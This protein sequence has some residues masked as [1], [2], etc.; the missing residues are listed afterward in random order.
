MDLNNLAP[1]FL[2]FHMIFSVL[3]CKVEVV[4]Q[5]QC[6]PATKSIS[7]GVS[8]Y[9]IVTEYSIMERKRLLIVIFTALDTMFV[10]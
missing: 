4:D 6:V 10:L 2:F 9:T 7:R 1:T 5:G 8:F 3:R